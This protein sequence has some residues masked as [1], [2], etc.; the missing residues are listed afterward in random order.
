VFKNALIPIGGNNLYYTS[1]Q[2]IPSWDNNY[3]TADPRFIDAT[4]A[5]FSIAANS[6]AYDVGAE[7]SLVSSSY[8]GTIRPQGSA[9]DIGAFEFVGQGSTQST[10]TTP[11]AIPV[12]IQVE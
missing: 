5:D 12:N 2:A 11:P 4:N 9:Y 6:G 10:D 1:T 8:D 7:I 3:I